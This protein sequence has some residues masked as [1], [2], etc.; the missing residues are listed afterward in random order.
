MIHIHCT[1]KN[2][3]STALQKLTIELAHGTNMPRVNAPRTGPPTIPKIP[4]AA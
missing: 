3:F 1:F 4:S 2:A